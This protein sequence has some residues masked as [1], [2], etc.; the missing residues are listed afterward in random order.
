MKKWRSAKSPS[1]FSADAKTDELICKAPLLS[2]YMKEFRLTDVDNASSSYL[3]KRSLE[4]RSKDCIEFS[5]ADALIERCIERIKANV[6]DPFML[7]ACLSLVVRAQ[8]D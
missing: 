6:D 7:A 3:A 1:H 4:T 2:D 8:V 5:D